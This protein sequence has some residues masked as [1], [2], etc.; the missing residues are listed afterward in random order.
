LNKKVI[1]LSAVVLMFVSGSIFGLHQLATSVQRRM[2]PV[3]IHS[4][5]D[6]AMETRA[7]HNELLVADLHSDAL[8]WDHD[9]AKNNQVGH[10]DFP[11][12][13]EGNVAV[14]V[15]SVVTKVPDNEGKSTYGG[16]LDQITLLAVVEL[17]PPQTWFN[18]TERALYQAHRLETLEK[19]LDGEFEIVTSKSD[20]TG[21]IAHR[22]ENPQ[23]VAGVLSLEGAHA[24]EGNL[25]NID[26]LYNAGFRIVGLTHHFDNDIGGASLGEGKKGL[27]DFGRDVVIRLE[28]EGMIIDLAHAS[29]TLIKDVLA[30][31][32]RPVIVTHTGVKGICVNA[33][34]LS[35]DDIKRIAERGGVI[36]IGYD[37]LFTCMAGVR[38]IVLSIQYVADLVGVEHV[39]LGSDFDGVITAPF[40]TSGIALITQGLIDAGFTPDEIRMIM[41]ENVINFLEKNLP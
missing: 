27:T 34:N 2:N 41:G 32:T 21:F 28:E 9:L 24:L 7:Y 40:D 31:T 39:A 36:G 10:V 6:I 3:L 33:R 23:P 14:Q 13:K 5:Y 17:W 30:I 25:D 19:Q 8:M 11:R 38:S 20:L 18:L 35:D 16:G 26:V 12:L 1:L 29:S 22:A 37:P 4:P 15:F